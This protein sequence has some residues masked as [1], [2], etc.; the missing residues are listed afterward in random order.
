LEE[1]GK[2]NPE[3]I[4]DLQE[5]EG[6]GMGENRQNGPDEGGQNQKNIQAGQKIIFQAELNRRVG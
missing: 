6:P 2:G 1:G 5:G 3:K 4:G